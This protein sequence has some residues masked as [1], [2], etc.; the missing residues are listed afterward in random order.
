M[1]ERLQTIASFLSRF[2]VLIYLLGLVFVGLFLL[3]LF[4]VSTAA[5]Y[6]LLIPSIV[7]F[8]W[9]LTLYCFS[10]LFISVPQRPDPK[11]KFWARWRSKFK[12]GLFW[13]LAILLLLLTAAV[14]ILSFQLL[15]TWMM[16]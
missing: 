8:C 3:S 10:T 14:L 4:E 7:G 11:A 13:E 9:A 2:R 1:I 16:A 6:D 5:E 15:R 12:R